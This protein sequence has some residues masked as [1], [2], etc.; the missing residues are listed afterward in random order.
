MNCTASTFFY[1]C[2]FLCVK[3]CG[4]NVAIFWLLFCCLD[5]FSSWLWMGGF[6]LASFQFSWHC[7]FFSFFLGKRYFIICRWYSSYK[8]LGGQKPMGGFHSREDGVFLFFFFLWC[9]CLL[10]A[11]DWKFLVNGICYLRCKWD[12]SIYRWCF[13]LFYLLLISG[14]RDICKISAL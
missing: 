4:L 13:G 2:Y 9:Y 1:K 7:V 3:S 14:V 11:F 12:I 10:V 6:F 5:G 8:N